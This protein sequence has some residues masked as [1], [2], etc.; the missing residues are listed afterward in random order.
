M[1]PFGAKYA[2]SDLHHQNKQ[3]KPDCF[4][5]LDYFDEPKAV[6]LDLEHGIHTDKL[7]LTV[8]EAVIRRWEETSAARHWMAKHQQIWSDGNKRIEN[9]MDGDIGL[10]KESCDYTVNE[11]QQIDMAIAYCLGRMHIIQPR[12]FTYL[13]L[14]ATLESLRQSLQND[15]IQRE[16]IRNTTNHLNAPPTLLL[17]DSLTT[18][19]EFTRVQEGLPTSRSS[20]NRSRGSGLSEKNE[21]YRQLVRLREE[22]N[23]MIVAASKN[24]LGSSIVYDGVRRDKGLRRNRTRGD[25]WDKLVTHCV[26]LHHIADGTMEDRNGYDFVATLSANDQNGDTNIFPYAVTAGGI[27]C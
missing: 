8:K 22:H 7:I 6:I 21:F 10:S 20:S 27:R 24:I 11:Q 17:I 16:N 14:V 18:L 5:T 19:D 15:Q 3:Q 9:G 23:V 26:A 4:A 13:N 1:N 2:S 25:A 12:D